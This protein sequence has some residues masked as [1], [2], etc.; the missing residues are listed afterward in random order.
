V[1]WLTDDGWQYSLTA[2]VI[3][4]NQEEEP[5][6]MKSSVKLSCGII[7]ILGV[8]TLTSALAADTAATSA[9]STPSPT[10]APA[11][12]PDAWRGSIALPLWAPQINGDITAAGRSKN[13][14]VSFNTLRN[15]LD[16][17]LG[18]AGSVG[19]D[20][21]DIF[22]NF[23][24][25]KFTGGNADPLG[26]H[27]D[28]QLKFIVANA[29]VAYQLVKTE[30]EHPF[31]LAGT[32]GVRFWYT[33]VDLDY[34]DALNNRIHNYN[35]WNLFDPVLGLRST[36]YLTDKLH[37]DVAGDGGGFNLSHDTDWT[38]SAV[39]MLSYDF[40]KWFTLSGGY[41]AL[42]LNEASGGSGKNNNSINLIFNG[43][44][45]NLNFRW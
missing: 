4:L 43:V 40:T 7:A 41:Q 22:G 8:L 5:I 44:A 2:S 25:M 42:A 30:S 29:G 35:N 39:G 34:H 6:T 37:L 38:W 26:G 28:W 21:F 32:A 45:V 11:P 10:L 24:Y 1:Q 18:L 9:M 14:D 31:I 17:S 36:K 33:S 23:G 19:K 16:A 13:V 20:K 12:N 27:T 15:H 3:R